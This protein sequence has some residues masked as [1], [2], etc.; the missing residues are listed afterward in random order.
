MLRYPSLNEFNFHRSNLSEIV[1]N[2]SE[3]L[4]GENDIWWIPSANYYFQKS[5]ICES[6]WSQLDPRIG[7]KYIF[8]RTGMK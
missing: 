2:D 1:F 8:V 7:M 4:I 5:P 6:D 3:L